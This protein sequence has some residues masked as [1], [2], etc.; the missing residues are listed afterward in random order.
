MRERDNYEKLFDKIDDFLKEL[1]EFENCTKWS[2]VS[3]LTLTEMAD[4][5]YQKAYADAANKIQKERPHISNEALER[6]AEMVA[7]SFVGKPMATAEELSFFPL[8]DEPIMAAAILGKE[9]Q[10]ED[11]RRKVYSQ[12]KYKVDSAVTAEALIDT[13]SEQRKGK[14]NNGGNDGTSLMCCIGE[15]GILPIGWSAMPGFR[16]ALGIAERGETNLQSYD[17]HDL[18]YVCNLLAQAA[19]G[20]GLTMMSAFGKWRACN[21][22]YYAVTKDKEVFEIVEGMKKDYPDMKFMHGYISHTLT[23]WVYDL[24]AY[25]DTLFA[26]YKT[27]L[28][29][30]Y[31][32]VLIVSTSN[33]ANSAVKFQPG[34]KVAGVVAPLAYELRYEHKA[35][36]SFDE[37]ARIMRERVVEGTKSIMPKFGNALDEV[38]ALH[39]VKIK[40][41]YN[42]LLRV[43]KAA[44]L[45]KA[46]AMEAAEM[47]KDVYGVEMGGKTIYPNVTA[48][49]LYATMMNAYAD[50]CQ[51]PK[52]T[53]RKKI[54]MADRIGL[55][56]R[57]NWEAYD[58]AEACVWDVK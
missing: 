1:L 39:K 53:D 27:F 9:F 2:S 47:F 49:D 33:T 38:D 24:S 46:E 4:P 7:R 34:L 17:P 58:T 10:K 57:Y 21:G 16:Q 31:Q 23:Y 15:S 6:E 55:T 54:D 36:G 40:Y 32:P 25:T 22:P 20:Y 3:P 41:G 26:Q 50:V 42:A 52:M 51:N 45:P 19:G 28:G 44:G 13:M 11:L 29:N 14:S 48:F 30:S 5:A 37:R 12:K 35:K 43:M 8:L 56:I 18:A